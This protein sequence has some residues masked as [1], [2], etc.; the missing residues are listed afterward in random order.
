MSETVRKQKLAFTGHLMLEGELYGQLRW[1][2]DAMRMYPWFDIPGVDMLYDHV[3][4]MTA[5][6]A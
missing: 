6:Q 5:K 2:I 3:E 1:T 4:L